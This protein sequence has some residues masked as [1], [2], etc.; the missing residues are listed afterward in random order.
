MMMTSSIAL[1]G[2]A[3]VTSSKFILDLFFY[4]SLLYEA[5]TFFLKHYRVLSCHFDKFAVVFIGMLKRQSQQIKAD[6]SSAEA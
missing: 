2:L 4:I 1:L 5:R 3:P 6:W